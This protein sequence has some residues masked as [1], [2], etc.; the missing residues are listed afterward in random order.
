[1]PPLE[2]DFAFRKTIWTYVEHAPMTGPRSLANIMCK[3]LQNGLI[4]APKKS[5]LLPYIAW[6][7]PQQFLYNHANDQN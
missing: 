6:V 2:L 7:R 5:D 1:M 4:G 3:I